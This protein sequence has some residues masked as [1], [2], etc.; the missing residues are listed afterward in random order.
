MLVSHA[1]PAFL[2]KVCVFPKIYLGSQVKHAPKIYLG[3]QVKH[4]ASSFCVAILQSYL[5]VIILLTEHFM[6]FGWLRF[7]SKSNGVLIKR[8]A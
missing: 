7:G 5:A 3:S 4:A 2:D 8:K 1:V 6:G